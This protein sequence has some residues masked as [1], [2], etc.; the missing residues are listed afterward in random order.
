MRL[1]P[2]V[3]LI[4]FT[5]LGCSHSTLSPASDL[6]GQWAWQFNRNPSGSSIT[7][8]LA[9]AESGVTGS[10]N[11]CGVGPACA[12]GPVTITGHSTR[13]TFQLT[14]RGNQG[15]VATYAGQV[16]G[17]N[18]LSGTWTQGT[19]SNTVIFYRN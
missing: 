2:L 1:L 11:I 5:L 16:I 8:S 9:T 10:G 12:P 18:Q 19:D 4:P 3:G 17:G 13:S 14:I 7:F 6:N 15:F